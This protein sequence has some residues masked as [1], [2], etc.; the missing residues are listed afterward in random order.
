MLEW[1]KSPSYSAN[2]FSAYYNAQEQGLG[3]T[4]QTVVTLNALHC[5]KVLILCPKSVLFSWKAEYEAWSTR[6]LKYCVMVTSSDVI[7]AKDADVV[8]VSYDLAKRPQVAPVL[9]SQNYHGLVLDESQ[10]IKSAESDRA[11]A[12]FKYLWPKSK[13]RVCLSGTPFTSSLADGW[14]TFSRMYPF[15]DFDSYAARYSYIRSTPWGIKYTG[16]RNHEELNKIIKSNFFQR[17]RKEEVLPDL[18]EKTFQQIILPSSYAVKVP[19]TEHEKLAAQIKALKKTIDEQ[20]GVSVPVSLGG[21]RKQQG[22][23]K[24]KPVIDFV[25]ELLD[26]DIPVVLVGIHTDVLSQFKTHFK[27]Y[28]PGFIDGSISAADRFTSVTRFQDG[29][30]NLFIGQL[31]A[32]GTGIT[33]TRSSTMVIAEMDYSPANLS[34]MCSRIHRISQKN[35]VTIYYFTVQGS[36]DEE[37]ERVVVAKAIDFNRVVEG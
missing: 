15:G 37:I 24:V 5:V 20:G 32:A 36:L 21:Q 7:K 26:Q 3:K 11:R 22:L 2:K 14:T 17:I 12:T 18:P 33:L 9:G 35:A 16:G 13:Y 30:T 8:I 19:K 4:V 6:K 29:K 31:V 25:Q 10:M 28:F 1:L 34:Q 23:A 27:D